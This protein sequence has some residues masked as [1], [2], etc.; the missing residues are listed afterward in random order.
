MSQHSLSAAT[1]AERVTVSRKRLPCWWGGGQPRGSRRPKISSA[2]TSCGGEKSAAASTSSRRLKSTAMTGWCSAGGI[3]GRLAMRRRV[4]AQG[5][6]GSTATSRRC[7]RGGTSHDRMCW[8]QL[9]EGACLSLH[10]SASS[11]RMISTRHSTDPGLGAPSR[12]RAQSRRRDQAVGRDISCRAGR[13]DRNPVSRSTRDDRLRA[14]GRELYSL[15]RA[16]R[17]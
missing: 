1:R 15:G 2:R 10:I 4:T 13:N 8:F 3:E 12:H 14:R 9:V 11:V 6:H 5:A 17:F 7:R 16:W